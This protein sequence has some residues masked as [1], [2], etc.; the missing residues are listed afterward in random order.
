MKSSSDVRPAIIQDLGNGSFH[1]NYNVT[2]RKIEDEE[3]GEKTF[4]DYD[5][6]QLW[7][8]PTYEKVTRAIIRSEIDETE[9]FSLINDYYAA[10]LGIE[11]D[12]ERKAKA[13]NDYKAY[14]THVAEIKAM[15]K[16]DLATAGLETNG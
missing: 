7:E 2:E 3:T 8:K 10:Q 1:Y 14:L 15:V 5:T 11:K 12:T 9:E 6:V 4:Y 13:E 16:N